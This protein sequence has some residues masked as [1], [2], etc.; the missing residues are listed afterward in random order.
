VPVSILLVW[1]SAAI[2]GFGQ[3]PSNDYRSELAAARA[4]VIQADSLTISGLDLGEP[5]PG[6]NVFTAVVKNKS[7]NEI[8][9]GLDLRAVPGLWLRRNM[10]AQFLFPVG[11]HW[12]RQIQG[13]Y[14]F[15]RMSED[16]TLRVQFFFPEVKAG[17]VTEF[18]KPFF[19]KTYAVGRNNPAVDFNEAKLFEKRA[20]EHFVIYCARSLGTGA[21]LD[22]I[23]EQREAAHRK[24]SEMLGTTDPEPIRLVFYSDPETKTRDTSHTGNGLAYDHTI[25]E[26]YGTIDP[27]HEMTHIL[28]ARL[29]DPPAMFNEGLAVYI[30]EQMGAD[31][32]KGLGSP[33]KKVDEAVKA[34]RSQGEFIPIDK[35]FTYTDIGPEG[36]QPAISYPEAA[37]FVKFLIS[38][39]GLEKFRQGYGSFQNADDAAAVQKN[40]ESFRA[41][42]G[43][44]P[45]EL[46]AEWLDGL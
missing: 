29:G 27:Y 18:G 15:V 34:H 39:Y 7:T 23:A 8:T 13:E 30:S 45:G 41:I 32:L 11:P 21:N 38:K 19:E 36:T 12:E 2:F 44:F 10:Q 4:E 14:E 42:Y 17:G 5:H 22:A 43:K 24:I 33:G 35:L 46:Q 1:F 6:K 9:L 31:A 3:S 37:S 40:K 26:V 20:T 25:I 28:A 16:A